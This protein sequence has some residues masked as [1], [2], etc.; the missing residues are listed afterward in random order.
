MVAGA[1]VVVV[2]EDVVVSLASVAVVVESSSPVTLK[3]LAISVAMS[4]ISGVMVN[5][6]WEVLSVLEL[7]AVALLSVDSVCV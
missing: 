5:S 1:V 2:V 7:V 4:G 6:I 3:A